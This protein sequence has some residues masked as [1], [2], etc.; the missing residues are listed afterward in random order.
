MRHFLATFSLVCVVVTTG[1][2]A[3]AAFI[4]PAIG[5]ARGESASS[6]DPEEPGSSNIQD[7]SHELETPD[8]PGQPDSRFYFRTGRG[9]SS[10]STSAPTV[11]CV[12][13]AAVPAMRVQ[14]TGGRLVMR[15]EREGACELPPPHLEGVFRPPR[16]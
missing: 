7:S 9:M 12:T 16:G 13:G 1:A 10:T 2:E 8:R 4:A 6:Y 3:H 15:W 11:S 5:M 14:L